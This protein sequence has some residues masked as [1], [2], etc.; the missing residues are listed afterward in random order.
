M[1]DFYPGTPES[2]NGR[3]LVS[4]V[5]VKLQLIQNVNHTRLFVCKTGEN[6]RILNAENTFN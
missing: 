2:K 5:H 1:G 6:K 4:K 3:N